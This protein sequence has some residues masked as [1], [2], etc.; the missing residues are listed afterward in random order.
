MIRQ[1]HWIIREDAR[2]EYRFSRSYPK[3]KIQVIQ[4]IF[5]LWVLL[6]SE[7]NGSKGSRVNMNMI[8]N[9]VKILFLQLWFLGQLACTS[10]Y[11]TGYLPFL[12]RNHLVYCLCWDLNLRPHGAQPT[13]LTT[14]LHPWVQLSNDTS[15]NCQTIKQQWKSIH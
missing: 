9:S 6:K 4:R 10:T 3:T 5:R 12:T 2:I 15:P 8:A 1:Q 13:S 11:S 7:L 14:R